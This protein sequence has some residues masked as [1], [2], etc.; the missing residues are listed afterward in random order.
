MS[1]APVKYITENQ[2]KKVFGQKFSIAEVRKNCKHLKLLKDFLFEI[3]YQRKQ[4]FEFKMKPKQGVMVDG[5]I[6][7]SPRIVGVERTDHEWIAT[8]F[9][10]MEA[11]LWSEDCS[12]R[13]QLRLL[14]RQG[15]R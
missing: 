11:R 15:D 8:S 14:Q 6:D 2:L 1:D 5:R 7:M 4:V 3:G 13:H 12:L 10:S 9:A